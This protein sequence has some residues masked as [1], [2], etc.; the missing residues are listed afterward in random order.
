MGAGLE[1]LTSL[2][3]IITTSILQS[4]DEG[5][6]GGIWRCGVVRLEGI[7]RVCEGCGVS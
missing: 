6:N 7:G 5:A 4:A 3:R 1:V 2:D